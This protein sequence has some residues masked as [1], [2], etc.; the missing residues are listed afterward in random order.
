MKDTTLIS[1]VGASSISMQYSGRSGR[2]S[3]GD[4]AAA[5]AESAPVKSFETALSRSNSAS[6]S[7]QP[8]RTGTADDILRAIGASG[9]STRNVT[10]NTRAASSTPARQNSVAGAGRTPTTPTRGGG[11]T[12][13]PT[14]P[15]NPTNPTDP[16]NPTNPTNPTKFS[17]L[18]QNWLDANTGVNANV[19]KAVLSRTQPFQMDGMDIRWS[20]GGTGKP[21]FTQRAVGVVTEASG[22]ELA[23]LFG[24]T[25][26]QSPFQI[27]G[28]SQRDQYI[29]MPNGQMVEASTLASQLNA[30]R[31]A[32][33]PFTATQ[34]VLEIYQLES[35]NFNL[36]TS[37]NAIDL[38]T[39]G[40]LNTGLPPGMLS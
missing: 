28:T 3:I 10:T 24:G 12:E 29:K 15:T 16:T 32:E 36:A 40:M 22:K 17:T 8:S 9:A 18:Q 30:A 11:T 37:T 35:Q 38:V 2:R 34:G 7:S 27:F 13:D 25:L 19:M 6:Q 26:V 14:D 21:E 1:P 33:D 23:Q 39:K 20:N 4:I 31:S 5:R